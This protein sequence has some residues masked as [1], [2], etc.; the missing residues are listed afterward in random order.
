M[1]KEKVILGF[2][3]GNIMVK[4]KQTD[5]LSPIG[6]FSMKFKSHGLFEQ[7]EDGSFRFPQFD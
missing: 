3:T 2:E 5:P 7:N 4:F 6:E 1:L